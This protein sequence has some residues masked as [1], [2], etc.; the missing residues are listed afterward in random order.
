MR[1]YSICDSL[2]VFFMGM[3]LSW[4]AH[5]WVNIQPLSWDG[6]VNILCLSNCSQWQSYEHKAFL[7]LAQ[8]L[9]FSS[10]GSG[11][12]KDLNCS[13]RFLIPQWLDRWCKFE[14]SVHD[15]GHVQSFARGRV[16]LDGV[17]S[18]LDIAT[19]RLASMGDVATTNK[20]QH[21]FNLSLT[22]C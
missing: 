8:S 22:N 20:E 4:P 19:S 1:A 9:A 21:W 11:K 14:W 13:Q 10:H 16:V 3:C 18:E 17:P 15:I 5:I 12:P 6:I 7:F 2:H